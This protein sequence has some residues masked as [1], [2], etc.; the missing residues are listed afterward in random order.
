MADKWAESHLRV[1]ETPAAK[2]KLEL[3][4]ELQFRDLCK[5]SDDDDVP[6]TTTALF[7]DDVPTCDAADP[8]AG[9][10]KNEQ[11][12]KLAIPEL[13]GVLHKFAD[14]KHGD[15]VEMHGKQKWTHTFRHG[16]HVASKVKDPD[17]ADDGV[18]H[19]D[20]HGKEITAEE[21]AALL[22][23]SAVKATAA[24]YVETSLAKLCGLAEYMHCEEGG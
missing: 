1:Y 5:V 23:E 19:F 10:I 2:P 17:M 7:D 11:H 13:A 6:V 20:G 16:E 8:I 15:V 9:F 22:K 4:V 18:M 3:N 12:R 21:H 24:T 14:V